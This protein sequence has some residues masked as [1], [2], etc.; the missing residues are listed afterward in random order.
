MGGH[1]GA[2]Q[3]EGVGEAANQE[4]HA[5]AGGH[6]GRD[7]HAQACA[8]MCGQGMSSFCGAQ[9]AALV[10]RPRTVVLV[11]GARIVKVDRHCLLH[12]QHAVRQ[13]PQQCSLLCPG[14][15]DCSY[16]TVTL[17]TEKGAA[18]AGS[19]RAPVSSWMYSMCMTPT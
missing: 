2:G 15:G 18:A 14:R 6:V 19:A 8:R 13:K 4:V 5:V 16:S 12:G 17:N 7:R 3:A 9:E 10:H 11:D 1:A